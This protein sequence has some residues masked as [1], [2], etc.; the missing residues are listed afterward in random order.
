[1]AARTETA[2][3]PEVKQKCKLAIGEMA[4]QFKNFRKD[5]RPETKKSSLRINRIRRQ[6]E[7][8]K[9]KKPE[10]KKRINKILGRVKKDLEDDSIGYPD[11]ILGLCTYTCDNINGYRRLIYDRGIATDY[12]PEIRKELKHS[13]KIAIDF[14]NQRNVCLFSFSLS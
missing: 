6:L 10:M 5:K 11:P 1:M 9:V 7:E 2:A 14:F 4:K 8:L 13:A 12:P 3:R